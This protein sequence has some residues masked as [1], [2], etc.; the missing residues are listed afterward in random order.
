[1]HKY[2]YRFKCLSISLMFSIHYPILGQRPDCDFEVTLQVEALSGMRIR[3]KP[4]VQAKIVGSAPYKSHVQACKEKFGQTTVE[5]ING[6]WRYVSFKNFKGYMWDGYTVPILVRESLSGSNISENETKALK[7]LEDSKIE[8]ENQ[9]GHQKSVVQTEQGK[10]PNLQTSSG[11]SSIFQDVKF[12]TESYPYCEDVTKIDRTYYYYGIYLE[13]DYYHIRPIDLSIE[14]RKDNPRGKMFFDIKPSNGDGTLFIIGLPEVFRDWK[15]IKNNDFI[16]TQINRT[17]TPGVRLE[18][19]PYQPGE[20]LGNI[21]L[22]TSG[23]VSTYVNDCPV[24]QNYRLQVE[25]NVDVKEIFD[26][27]NQIQYFGKCGVPDIYWFGDLNQDG[28]TDFIL[29]SEY[30]GFSVFTLFFSQPNE[31]E[32]FKKVAEWQVEDC[33]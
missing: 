33:D 4:D 28:Y 32:K 23:T 30:P 29:V 3:E 9:H 14:L 24:V 17:L 1:M 26:I 27:T 20:S 11:K 10:K 13:D 2:I 6:F 25:L 18:L 8:A 5:G 15:K 21:R 22:M 12:L 16:L 19:Y 31:R 7:A